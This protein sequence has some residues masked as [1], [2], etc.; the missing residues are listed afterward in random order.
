MLMQVLVFKTNL[1]QPRD[2][3]KVQPY[4][5]VHPHIQRWNVDLQDCDNILRIE[6]EQLQPVEIEK[7][8]LTAGYYCEAL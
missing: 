1:T 2:V 8:L 5:Q 3:R 7:I 6:T 4:L